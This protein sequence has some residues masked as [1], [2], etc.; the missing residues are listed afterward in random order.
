MTATPSPST[1][2][3][4]ARATGRHYVRKASTTSTGARITAAAAAMIAWCAG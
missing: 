1:S 2:T 3:V 4:A